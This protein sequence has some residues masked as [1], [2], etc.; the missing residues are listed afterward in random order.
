MGEKVRVRVGGRWY[1]VEVGDLDS[2]PVR[3]IVDGV[4]VDVSLGDLLGAAN[5]P[6]GAPSGR[7]AA[8]RSPQAR[9]EFF[10][11]VAGVIVSVAVAVGDQVVTGDEVCDIE[12][13]D[14]VKTLRADWSGVVKGVKVEAGQEVSAGQL[15]AELE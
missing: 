11:P 8:I 5:A 15:I 12:L 1:E 7:N 6:Q 9:K 10:A 4:E 14:G 2:D 13:M 3:T